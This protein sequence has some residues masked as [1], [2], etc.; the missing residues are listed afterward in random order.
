MF[1][2][3]IEFDSEFFKTVISADV[4]FRFRITNVQKLCETRYVIIITENY[5]SFLLYVEINFSIF[6]IDL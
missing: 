1:S 5:Y 2:F 4:P 3:K 6:I